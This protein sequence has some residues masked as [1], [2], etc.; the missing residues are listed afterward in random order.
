MPQKHQHLQRRARQQAA[1]ERQAAYDKL[2]LK[3]KLA[4]ALERGHDNT[5]EVKRLRAQVKS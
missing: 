4:R 2:S 1:T 5:D 3:E